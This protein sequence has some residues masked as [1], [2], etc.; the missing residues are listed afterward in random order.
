MKPKYITEHE[1]AL[2][3]ELMTKAV[4]DTPHVFL[5]GACKRHSDEYGTGAIYDDGDIK[6]K[7]TWIDSIRVFIINARNLNPMSRSQFSW[8]T[9]DF[10]NAVRFIRRE[11]FLNA[12]R[13]SQP[14]IPD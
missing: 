6:V 7:V 2:L 4:A 14:R 1:D 5:A 10:D 13:R 3:L 8:S 11:Q 12:Q 9:E